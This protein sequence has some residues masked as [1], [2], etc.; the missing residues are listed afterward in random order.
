MTTH[1]FFKLF[2][3]IIITKYVSCFRREGN[4]ILSLNLVSSWLGAMRF[5]RVSNN[6]PT[7]GITEVTNHILCLLPL[8]H[9]IVRISGLFATNIR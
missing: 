9:M 1:D 6:F 5:P 4:I 2:H 8:P 3:F 7:E